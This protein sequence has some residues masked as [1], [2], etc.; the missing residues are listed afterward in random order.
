MQGAAPDSQ[1][2]PG[3][4][5]CLSMAALVLW[6]SVCFLGDRGCCGHSVTVSVR[7]VGQDFK[8]GEMVVNGAIIGREA[9]H[10][11]LVKVACHTTIGKEIS[12]RQQSQILSTPGT[13]KGSL[14]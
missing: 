2:H 1:C 8:T 14:A 11:Q 4:S 5:E 3:L 12:V 9:T 10:W 7:G 6:D 13:G